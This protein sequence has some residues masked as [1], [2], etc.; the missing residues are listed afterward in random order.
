MT[1]ARRK[2]L[3][4]RKRLFTN[5]STKLPSKRNQGA[6]QSRQNYGSN[7]TAPDLD[8]SALEIAKTD[9]LTRLQC[10]AT[11]I[12]SIEKA[13]RLQRNSIDNS[14]IEYR[15]NRIRA[16]VA[17]AVCKRRLK[18]VGSL[19]RQLLYPRNRQTKAMEHGQM[20]EP[21]AIA[22]FAKKMGCIVNSTGLFIHK[23]YGFL[24]P[25]QTG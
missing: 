24:G 7:A 14:W 20:Y 22:A 17:G 9:F 3:S 6:N 12:L 4:A 1:T 18:T 25:V 19:V 16:S 8:C 10:T 21:V 5:A 15:K 23:E 11:E 13:N 2:K